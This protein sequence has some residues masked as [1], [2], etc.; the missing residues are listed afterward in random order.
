MAD[1]VQSQITAITYKGTGTGSPSLFEEVTNL[2]AQ[3]FAQ[4]EAP[5]FEMGRS[6]RS[7]V[8][9]IQ[10]ITNAIIPVVDLPTTLG[11]ICLFN[12]ANPGSNPPRYLVVKRLSW[13]YASGTLAALAMASSHLAA[14]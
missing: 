1:P 12:G 13:S 2:G 7:F 9:G 11:P 14:A 6:G 5:G 4:L 10:A 8:G 3:R